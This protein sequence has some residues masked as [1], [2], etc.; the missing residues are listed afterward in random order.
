MNDLINSKII[1]AANAVAM[2]ICKVHEVEKSN[3]F[4]C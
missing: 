2:G 3:F 1:N 4:F